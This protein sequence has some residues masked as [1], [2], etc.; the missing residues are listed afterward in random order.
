M[1]KVLNSDK[2]CLMENILSTSAYTVFSDTS[3]GV[4]VKG[5]SCTVINGALATELAR[6]MN[7]L[8]FS[9]KKG[10]KAKIRFY[11]ILVSQVTQSESSGSSKCSWSSRRSSHPHVFYRIVVLRNFSNSRKN[12]YKGVQFLFDAAGPDLFRPSKKLVKVNTVH[13]NKDYI[14]DRSRQVFLVILVRITFAK[15]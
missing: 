2:R 1:L 9:N 5:L 7:L 8:L 14:N 10:K 12:I 3:K 4:T 11:L 15:F 13:I 6:W